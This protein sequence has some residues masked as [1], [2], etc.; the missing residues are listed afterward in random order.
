MVRVA[1]RPAL[2]WVNR[3]LCNYRNPDLKRQS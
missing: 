3:D 2:I 1:L